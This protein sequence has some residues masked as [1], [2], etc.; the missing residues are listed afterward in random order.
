M[1]KNNIV[2]PPLVMEE[3]EST[4][5]KVFTRIIW[6]RKTTVGGKSLMQENIEL[7]EKIAILEK[8]LGKYK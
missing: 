1:K 7:K 4:E 3:K 5:K 2:E 6:E 8:E